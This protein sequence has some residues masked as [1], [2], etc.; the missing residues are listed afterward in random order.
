MKKTKNK[1]KKLPFSE[2]LRR[3]LKSR[4]FL[5]NFTLIM[6]MITLMFLAFSLIIYRQSASILEKE[7]T[8]S[9][10]YRLEASA[11]AVDKHMKDMRYIAATLD[12]NQMVQAFFSYS[13]PD[14]IY[15][16]FDRKLQ[17]Q[18][19]AYV[20]SYS[21]IDSIYLYS[22]RSNSILT[23][24][25]RANVSYFCDTNWMD[26]FTE[27][28]EGFQIFFRAKNNA[29]PY[30]LCLM[31]QLKTNSYNG[32]IVIN[33]NLSNLSFLQEPEDND[34]QQIFLISDDGKILFR[35]GQRQLTEPLN[36]IPELVN[37]K[38]DKDT[39][40]TLAETPEPYAYA[41]IHSVDYPWSYVSV[42][43]LQEYTSRLSS[44]RA[45]ITALFC[46]LFFAA[47]FLA[48]LFSMRSV[49]P[50][51]NLLA[52]LQNPQKALSRELHSDAQIA[53]IA[54]KVT[55]YIQQNQ[56]LSNELTARLNLLNETKLLALQ[57]QINPHFLFN[58]LNMIHI[59]ESEALGYDHKIP[60]ITLN[61]SKLLRYA[62]ES[63]DLVTLDTELKFTKLYISILQERY[64]NKLH[65]V[66]EISD[67][68]LPAKVPKLFIQPII[69][70]AIFHGLAE[71]MDENSTLFLSCQ[72]CGKTC[73]VTVR[74]NGI[75]MKPE[76]LTQLRTILD[77][78]VSFKGS[79]GLKNI[80]TRMNLLY[81]EEFSIE[82][83]SKEGEGSSFLLRFPFMK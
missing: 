74:D 49:K 73:I 3:L 54:D 68:S 60:N 47:V 30:V 67:A 19:K 65:V 2:L 14:S 4:M 53:Y 43:H 42:T 37:F 17:E 66:Y 7:F 69:E 20:N 78:S 28:P 46:A 51:Q 57:S 10:R 79:I 33:L 16:D 55:S 5:M 59:L 11:Q 41:Q 75:G 81:G 29:Y 62:I 25:E 12:T 77:D 71:K 70:N 58:T 52:M 21:S 63:T 48:F 6:G 1:L 24:A 38:P 31:K 56:K 18:I 44:S 34:Y 15:T 82:I 50:I 80:V 83:Q 22:Q 35:N 76:T 13:N 9:G 8:A 61:L 72:T 36:T 23:A 45:M 32:A 27:E 40:S 39:F 64:G 26:H